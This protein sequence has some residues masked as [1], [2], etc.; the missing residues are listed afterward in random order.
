MAPNK[1]TKK[2][3]IE[4]GVIPSRIDFFKCATD[5]K[6]LISIAEERECDWVTY[7]RGPTR[8]YGLAE[9]WY[10]KAK[11]IIENGKCVLLI[12]MDRNYHDDVRDFEEIIRGC[13]CQIVEV[14]S[15]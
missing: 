1:I 15:D 9:D 12:D 4:E 10:Y 6:R 2:S 14:R 3:L 7:A 8:F 5:I 13:G 11:E